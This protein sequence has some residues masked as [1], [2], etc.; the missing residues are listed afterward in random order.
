MSMNRVLASF[1]LVLGALALVGCIENGGGGD[2]GSGGGTTTETL[3]V[4]E[5]AACPATENEASVAAC[6]GTFECWYPAT[7]EGCTDSKHLVTCIDHRMLVLKALT[8]APL[9]TLVCDPRGDWAVAPKE[10]FPQDTNINPDLVTYTMHVVEG[11][12][13]ILYSA[14]DGE[15]LLS[16]GGCKYASARDWQY[17]TDTNHLAV[18]IDFSVT[19]ADGLYDLQCF[20]EC[21]VIG[22]VPFTAT[23]LP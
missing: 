7:K 12:D 14:E 20:G 22:T 13:G 11:S 1:S 8:C 17:N 15:A 18:T 9:D 4:T 21:G 10:P 6:D 23:K 5:A 3:T 2:G 16:D 19:P